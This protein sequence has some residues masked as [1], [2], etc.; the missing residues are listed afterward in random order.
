MTSKT[1]LPDNQNNFTG[2]EGADRLETGSIIPGEEITKTREAIASL[3]LTDEDLK[4]IEKYFDFSDDGNFT[5]QEQ[6]VFK[7]KMKINPAFLEAFQDESF[8]R[9][10]IVLNMQRMSNKYLTEKDEAK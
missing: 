6:E 1:S 4:L 8:L 3:E 5:E 7:Q 2:N 9:R 10:E